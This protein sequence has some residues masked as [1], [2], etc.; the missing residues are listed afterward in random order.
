[1]SDFCESQCGS[2]S[3]V[4]YYPQ[5]DPWTMSE[6]HCVGATPMET[7]GS[8]S[9]S[10]PAG[11]SSALGLSVWASG[12]GGQ[13]SSP[14]STSSPSIGSTTMEGSL[15]DSLGYLPRVSGGVWDGL[16]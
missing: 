10:S 5:L 12:S 13:R 4:H 9:S 3:Q 1:M 8:A 15:L 11:R 2:S 14:L 7:S 16:M 6:N